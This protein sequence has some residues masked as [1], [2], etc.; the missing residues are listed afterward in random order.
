VLWLGYAMVGVTLNAPAKM[1]LVASTALVLSWLTSAG[2]SAIVATV[3][4]APNKAMAEASAR[5]PAVI[6]DQTQ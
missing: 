6:A 3:A 5:P 1:I 4:K 2:A